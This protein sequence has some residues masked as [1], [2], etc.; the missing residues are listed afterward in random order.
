VLYHLE[1][2][3]PS[4]HEAVRFWLLFGLSAARSGQVERAADAL[5]R[6]F[7]LGGSPRSSAD[8]KALFSAAVR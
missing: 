2:V 6:A 4:A 3:S 7:E 1:G 5:E 8:V